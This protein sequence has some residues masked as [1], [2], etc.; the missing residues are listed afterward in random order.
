MHP[1]MALPANARAGMVL[2]GMGG[3]FAACT[4][5]PIAS[6][7]MVSEITGSYGLVVP[8][9]MTCASAYL[10]SRSFTMNESQVA[11][12]SDSPA[13]RGDFLLNVLEGIKVRDALLERA[14]PEMF[15]AET[16][17]NE[18]LQRIKVSRATVFPIVD[19]QECLVGMFSL[20]DIR[21]I[22]NE[23]AVGKLVVAGDLGTTNVPYVTRDM[24]LDQALHLFTKT[25]LDDLP[26]VEVDDPRQPASRTTVSR[27]IR[28]P[29]GPVG[30]VR[31][32]GML[33][34]RDL[35]SAYDRALH[36]MV[37]AEA[38][39]KQRSQLT[40]E[41]PQPDLAAELAARQDAPPAGTEAPLKQESDLL[42]EPP[43]EEMRGR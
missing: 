9:M 35:I 17:F 5:T 19:E 39:E 42:Q 33:S 4:K 16:P 10:L 21:Q 13:H 6:L 38:L 26:V 31:V 3:V 41:L 1:I 8:L 23:Q 27:V 43:E 32:I 7:V 18:V 40:V 24:N 20:G 30:T 29:R 37:R 28:P 2:V 34:R 14:K 25:N 11:G 15:K 12:I 36:A 22:M